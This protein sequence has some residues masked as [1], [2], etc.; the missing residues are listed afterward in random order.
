MTNFNGAYQTSDT[1]LACYLIT[2]G[3]I[4]ND[5]DYSQPRFIF[6]FRESHTTLQ[7]HEHIYIAGKATVDPAT[8]SRVNRKLMRTM[9][10]LSQW[11]G[12]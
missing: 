1:S 12:A 3:F 2:L 4:L 8:Y 11:G 7:E 9:K 5:I 6:T 10:N